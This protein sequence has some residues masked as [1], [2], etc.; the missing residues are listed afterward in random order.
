MATVKNSDILI[1]LT[2]VQVQL[3]HS[4]EM[5]LIADQGS[6]DCRPQGWEQR[7]RE[8]SHELPIVPNKD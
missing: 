5:V 1:V 3:A 2:A 4:M 8:V 6:E 7:L